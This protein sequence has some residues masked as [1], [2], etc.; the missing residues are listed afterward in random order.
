V[1]EANTRG[2]QRPQQRLE[3]HD[4]LGEIQRNQRQLTRSREVQQALQKTVHT[5]SRGQN[6]VDF[7]GNSGALLEEGG[8][9]Q[10]RVRANRRDDV[11]QVVREAAREL[12]ENFHLLRLPEP[13]LQ[14]NEFAHVF[15]EEL[16]LPLPRNSIEDHTAD[17][18]IAELLEK[19]P[20]PRL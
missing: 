17:Q 14:L 18:L 6:V 8:A 7:L 16:E 1:R 20:A 10:V 9:Q 11:V 19:V 4:Q 3:A 12:A 13:C 5:P 15:R 2:K